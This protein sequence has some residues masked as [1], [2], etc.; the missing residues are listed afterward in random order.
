VGSCTN[1]VAR[2]FHHGIRNWRGGRK[3]FCDCALLDIDP[4]ELLLTAS[5]DNFICS[6]AGETHTAE[7]FHVWQA[8]V[9]LCKASPG[10]KVHALVRDGDDATIAEEKLFYWYIVGRS[11]LV[12]AHVSAI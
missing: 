10:G 3:S 12:A 4:V 8:D 7:V 11:S 1:A 5:N 6:L 2:A 9:P